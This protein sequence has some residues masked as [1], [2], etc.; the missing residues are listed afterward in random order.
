MDSWTLV[1]IDDINIGEVHAMEKAKSLFS[2]MKEQRTIHATYCEE[3][4]IDIKRRASEI[5]MVIN[6]QKT[7]L[8]CI[9][10]FVILCHT[11]ERVTAGSIA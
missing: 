9:S 6:D 1:Y 8:L 2:Q 3:K 11:S 4:F 5:G 10:D 7:Q